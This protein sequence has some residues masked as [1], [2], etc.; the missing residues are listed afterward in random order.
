MVSKDLLVFSDYDQIHV[1]DRGADDVPSGWH[2]EHAASGYLAPEEDGAA[3]ATGVN[4]YVTVAVEVIDGPPAVDGDVGEIVT[5]C[6]FRVPS[7][8]V[9]VGCPTTPLEDGPVV[10]VPAG[11]VR[12]RARLAW[13]PDALEEP[14][15]EVVAAGELDESSFPPYL[16]GVAAVEV[17][18]RVRVQLW[19]AEPAG[20]LLV[21]GWVAGRYVW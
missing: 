1:T 21:R 11:W 15:T 8:Q 6:S 5:E 9:V 18:Q 13:W 4:G 19:A 20:P 7:G 10:G 2:L 16:V 17:S 12:L 14:R 3:I